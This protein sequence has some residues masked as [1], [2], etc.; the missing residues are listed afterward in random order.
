[1]PWASG[2]LGLWPPAWAF[3]CLGLWLPWPWVAWAF[4]CLGIWLPVP[5][6]A[7]GFGHLGL[8]PLTFYRGALCSQAPDVL[9]RFIFVRIVSSLTLYDAYFR[10]TV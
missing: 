9:Q 1:M 10:T 2:H 3:G 8:R 6:A 5:L 4:G 7:W